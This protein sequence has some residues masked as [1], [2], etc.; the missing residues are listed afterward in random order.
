[1]TRL[2]FAVVA[3]VCF[4]ATL[5]TSAQPSGK[6]YRVGILSARSATEPNADIEAFRQR[7]R[8][9]GQRESDS[10]RF[11]HRWDER[12]ER[13]PEL[14]AQLVRLNVDAIFAV[15]TE[16]ALAAKHATKTIPIVFAPVGD[17]V[18]SGVVASLA[19]PGGNVTG[20]THIPRDLIAKL[21]GLLKDVAPKTARVAVLIRTRNPSAPLVLQ[22][23]GAGAR[24][25]GVS[26][27]IVDIP[28]PKDIPT[29][30]AAIRR[31]KPDALIVTAAAPVT[32]AEATEFAK[33]AGLP[34]I[35][36]R[37][38]FVDA[39]GLMSYGTNWLEMFRRAAGYVDKILKGARPADLP[40]EQPTKFEFVVNLRTAKVLGFTIPPSVLVRADEVI[41]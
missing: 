39:G 5:V 18:G 34:A 31:S 37:R 30:F 40:V 6:L 32:A 25:L 19:R 4:A 41:Q 33:K 10:L 17:P 12:R 11:E 13:L 16:S 35:S 20:F 14:A 21:V 26:L 38:D 23:A 15:G 9:L 2:F 3:L 22:E 27:E 36:E 1:M 7:L 24:S 28:G 8:E 29:A